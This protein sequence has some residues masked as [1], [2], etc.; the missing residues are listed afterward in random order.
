[1]ARSKPI[2]ATHR[3]DGQPD[4]ARDSLD[5]YAHL[6]ADMSIEIIKDANSGDMAARAHVLHSERFAAILDSFDIDPDVARQALQKQW[7]EID[8]NKDALRLAR[9]K[10]PDENRRFF[11]VPEVDSE[12]YMTIKAIANKV[13]RTPSD[14]YALIAR[15]NIRRVT[16]TEETPFGKRKTVRA[17][18]NDVRAE[19]E[20]SRPYRGKAF[21]QSIGLQ[22]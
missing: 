15:R 19:I 13:A 7:K 1:M 6:A 18:L 16:R 11:V 2:P 9:R 10:A 22:K 12:G 8:A 20:K 17:M 5:G 21:R 3:L 4:Y 14:V